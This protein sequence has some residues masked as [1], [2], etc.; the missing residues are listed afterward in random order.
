MLSSVIIKFHLTSIFWKIAL[1]IDPNLSLMFLICV[2]LIKNN[3]Y[4][5][6]PGG[7]HFIFTS[8][9]SAVGRYPAKEVINIYKDR[10]MLRLA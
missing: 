8:C 4:E 2:F 5:E 10:W 6:F 7:R 1:Q 3:V 9:F